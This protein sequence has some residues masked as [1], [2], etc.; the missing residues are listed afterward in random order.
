MNVQQWILAAAVACAT[1]AAVNAT[2]QELFRDELAS[3]AGW[4]VNA[5][6]ADSA[7]VFGYDYSADGIPEAPNSQGADA[8]TS[9]VKLTSNTAE[10]A[11]L[12]A[13][14][15]YPIGQSFSGKYQLRFD[16]WMNYD[17][18]ERINGG[19]NGTTEFIGGGVGYDNT[20]ADIGPGLQAIATG[21]GGS[22]SDWR[23]FA[24]GAFLDPA[25]MNAQ[26]R[27]NANPA[28]SDFLPGAS[29]PASQFHLS[30]PPGTPG[31]PGF[32]WVT[33]EI[34]TDNGFGVVNIEKP[35]GD[36]L[37]IATLTQ[38]DRPF[39][40]DGNI[41]IFYADFFTSISPRPDVTFGIIDNVVVS[42][43][44]EPATAVLVVLGLGGV[45]AVRRRR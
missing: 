39:T 40:S 4:G 42:R 32:Q 43:V 10:P 33:F 11:S 17:V 45:L 26:D 6:S 30:Y 20:A 2:A 18:D 5:T 19:S 8:A 24:D 27:N 28:Y 35:D 15:L 3:G 1:V 25:E 16:A 44:P 7:A 12:E 9:G 22:G 14:T 29:P 37:R 31:V 34:T 41:G 23:V 21:D 38:A 36:R 13:M